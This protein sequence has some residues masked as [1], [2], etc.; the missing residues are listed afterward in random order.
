MK[1]G[2][3]ITLQDAQGSA[4]KPT[5]DELLRLKRLERPD[6]AFWQRFEQ[7]MR[8]K[9][10][11]A[12]IEPRP[13]WHGAALLG[14]RFAPLAIPATL[15]LAAVFAVA[16]FNLQVNRPEGINIAKKG[17][18]YIA[19]N[20]SPGTGHTEN[21]VAPAKGGRDEVKTYAKIAD[22]PMFEALEPALASPTLTPAAFAGKS[23]GVKNFNETDDTKAKGQS[24]AAPRELLRSNQE[25]AGGDSP[26]AA[27][28]FV[29]TD[30]L[31]LPTISAEQSGLSNDAIELESR[32]S[33]RQERL[34]ALADERVEANSAADIAHVRERMV[35]RLDSEESRLA[36]AS[37]LGVGGDRFSLRF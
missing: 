35:H 15:G 27:E 4:G 21:T 18:A 8:E 1:Y 2:H 24:P 19:W 14:T 11:A 23:D 6:A 5:L 20:A 26:P 22:K 29:A 17:T 10:L 37:R 9:Q 28:S 31:A 13:W 30:F 7:G 12:I 32:L 3:K 16:I 36:S 33:A 34:L 25:L